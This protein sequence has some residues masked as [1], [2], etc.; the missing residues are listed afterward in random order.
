[1]AVTSPT[2]HLDGRF[3]GGMQYCVSCVVDVLTEQIDDFT[4][5]AAVEHPCHRVLR[6]FVVRSGSVSVHVT[7]CSA[8][9]VIC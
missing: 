5:I 3:V 6:S 7:P 8:V 1:M 4:E 9:L 2:R